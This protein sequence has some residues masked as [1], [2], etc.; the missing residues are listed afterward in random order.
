MT[1][2]NLDFLFKPRSVALIGASKR[3]G[4][5]DPFLIANQHAERA[6]RFPDMKLA[7]PAQSEGTRDVPHYTTALHCK[8]SVLSGHFLRTGLNNC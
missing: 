7:P 4:I 3:P 5:R 8:G 6:R 2:R 1:I